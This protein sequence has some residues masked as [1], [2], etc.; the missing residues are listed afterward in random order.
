MLNKPSLAISCLALLA[1]SGCVIAPG[2]DPVYY[3]DLDVQLTINGTTD[4][5]EC[6]YYQID[7]ADINIY[8]SSDNFVLGAQPI[9]EDF[10]AL[11]ANLAYDAYFVDVQLFGYAGEEASAIVSTQLGV[12]SGLTI[13]E[14]DFPDGSIY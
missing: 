14:L 8:D 10:G 7:Y 5:G 3:G 13:Y 1:T 4:P 12:E 9:C 11:F 6:S 2:P